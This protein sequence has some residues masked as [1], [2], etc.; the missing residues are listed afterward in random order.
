VNDG[1][2]LQAADNNARWCDAVCRAHGVPG[3]FHDTY[4]INHGNVPPYTSKLITLAPA[5]REQQLAAVQALLDA[6]PKSYFSVKDAFQCLELDL[7]GFQVLFQAIWIYREPGARLPAGRDEQL[8][9]SAVR[10]PDE[11]A[12][13]ERAWRGSPANAAV[14]G[15]PRVFVPSLLG[16]PGV[17][18]WPASATVRLWRRRC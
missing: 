13:W 10:E 7:L 16:E 1:R 3:R 14:D 9:W 17:S 2:A 11:L 4:W 15:Q 12:D 8:V 6:E 18:F 5:D